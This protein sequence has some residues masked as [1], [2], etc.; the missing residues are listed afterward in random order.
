MSSRPS[1]ADVRDVLAVH[2]PG[3]RIGA[4]VELGA[5]LENVAYEVDGALV[6]R[7]SREPDPVRR[8][9]LIGHEARLL[10]AVARVSP[11]PVPEPV[12]AAAELGCLAY[13]KLPGVPLSELSGPGCSEHGAEIA[14][15]LGE[16]IA[17][18][19]AQPVERWSGLVDVDDQPPAEW[20]R[21]AAELHEGVAEHVPPAHRRAVAEFFDSPPPERGHDLVFSHNDLGI[22]HVLVDPAGW[23]VTGVIDWSD[24]ALVDPAYDFGLLHRDLGPVALRAALGRYPAGAEAL[25]ERAVFYARC[26]V[27]ED[28]A[29][30]VDTGRAGYLDRGVAAMAWLFP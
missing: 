10:S 25:A 14:A 3:R 20:L 19:H 23:T 6:V 26:S 17:A 11:L 30:G 4:V 13:A 27:F 29:Y 24:A 7:F 15:T 9:E 16:W 1:I 5:G 28:L 18:L 2:L 12:F 21:E 8:A 22:E